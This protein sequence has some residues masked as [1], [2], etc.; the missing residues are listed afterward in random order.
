MKIIKFRRYVFITNN[1]KR[2]ARAKI[3]VQHFIKAPN[4]EIAIDNDIW[5]YKDVSPEADTASATVKKKFRVTF[6]IMANYKSSKPGS[7][8]KQKPNFTKALIVI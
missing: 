1:D 8:N 3:D 5:V 2:Q 6:F 4:N 7:N